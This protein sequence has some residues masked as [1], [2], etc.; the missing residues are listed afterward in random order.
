MKNR[1]ISSYPEAKKL[2]ETLGRYLDEIVSLARLL[3]HELQIAVRSEKDLQ[4]A[5]QKLDRAL[6]IFRLKLLKTLFILSSITLIFGLATQLFHKQETLAG[7][8]RASV[9]Q[10][11]GRHS[12]VDRFSMSSPSPTPTPPSQPKK[13]AVR[14]AAR[15]LPTTTILPTPASVEPTP[16][17]SS[18]PS[19]TPPVL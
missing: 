13:K 10:T 9:P 7:P 15:P 14:T 4:R 18:G 17:T 5:I 8:L 12:W 1:L 11:I 19:A 2:Q 6:D 16:S 3:Y